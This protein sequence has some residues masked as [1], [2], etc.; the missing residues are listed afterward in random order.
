MGLAAEIAE[1]SVDLPAF[2][3][4]MIATSAR[5]LSSIA[6]RRSAPGRPGFAKRGAWRV[7]VAKCWL[8]QPPL[9]P[10][11][12]RTR[13][14][15]LT[16]SATSSPLSASV[17]T[18]PERQ[19][20]LDVLAGLAVAVGAHA[21]LAAARP[22]RVLVAEVVERVVRRIGDG[23]DRAA[24]SAVASGGPPL[25]DELLPPEGDAAVAAV[26]GLHVDLGGI[27][28]HGQRCRDEREPEAR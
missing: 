27:D 7:G 8:P 15:A 16:R 28:E 19:T 10:L 25:R 23:P 14:P 17:T 6:S 22:I 5:S 18:E 2:G 13:S 21:V 9:P 11:T 24:V 12:R 3:N 20:H 1:I 26:A 4:P